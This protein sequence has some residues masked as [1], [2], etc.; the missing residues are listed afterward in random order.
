MCV[1]GYNLT[2]K[3]LDFK[4]MINNP[5]AWKNFSQ[6]GSDMLGA[7][8][9]IAE[10]KEYE[11]KPEEVYSQNKEPTIND[12]F[13]GE[14]IKSIEGDRYE[15]KIRTM[16]NKELIIKEVGSECGAMACETEINVWKPKKT[17]LSL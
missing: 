7:L 4:I 1:I 2:E 14:I 10:G 15:V 17:I 13:R 6:E 12:L 11:E 8:L 9:E 5:S 3:I 16:N